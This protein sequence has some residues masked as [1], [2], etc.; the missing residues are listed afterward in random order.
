MKNFKSIASLTLVIVLLLS[1][2]VIGVACKKKEAPKPVV[3]KPVQQEAPAPER[4]FW[5]LTGIEV[6]NPKILKKRPVSVKIENSPASRPQTGLNSA[7]IV[8]ETMVEGGL[9]RFNAIFQS[10]LPE[11]AGPVRSA[12]LS[13]IWIVPQYDALFYYSGSN[14]QVLNRIKDV[15]L[16]TFTENN[17]GAQF[18]RLKTRKAPHNLYFKFS[19]LEDAVAR[20][21]YRRGYKEAPL[22][23][24]Y[25][26]LASLE[27]T[28]TASKVQVNISNYATPTWE[29]DA[30]NRV[31]LRSEG[32]TPLKDA[33]GDKQIQA[34][35]V[36]VMWATY[37]QQSAVDA[38]KN[39]T[40]DTDLGSGGKAQVFKDGQVYSGTWVGSASA[41][42]KFIDAAGK[43]I[44]LNP[45]NTWFEVI[46]L[47]KTVTLT[48]KL[49]Q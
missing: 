45:G 30:T 39:N 48:E 3:K 38:A 49:P 22:G 7:D 46:P 36:V 37:T 29:F 13:D 34:T 28:L 10:Q 9:T 27:T 4:Y 41:P 42:P 33:N 8:Y 15:K 21:K 25:G 40:F 43:P 35:N 11:Q 31:Y 5:P 47:D 14:K 19:E 24:E 6:D 17:A 1:A 26:E 2:S 23:L 12:R 20:E 16:N 44:L 18:Y 32:S